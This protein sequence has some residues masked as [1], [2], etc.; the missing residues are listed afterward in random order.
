M[1]HL[2]ILE[3]ERFLPTVFGDEY[4]RYKRETGRYLAFPIGKK[5]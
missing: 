3:E 1:F 4:V 5:P 2:Q